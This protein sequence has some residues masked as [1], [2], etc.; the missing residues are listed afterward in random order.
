MKH[1]VVLFSFFFNCVAAIGQ[2]GTLTGTIVQ[3]DSN[4][5]LSGVS[6]YLDGV[7]LGTS[8][9]SHGRY[10]ITKIPVGEYTLVVS[11]IGYFT[12]RSQVHIG[13]D[14]VVNANFTMIE[15]ISTLAE[16]TIMTGGSSG[17][18]D[19]PGSVH[20]I[21]P[22]EIQRFNYTDI[23][24]ILRA[25]PGVN[26]QEEDGFGLRPNIGL[27]GTGVERS[28]KITVMEDGILMA[29]APYAA[30]AAYYFP[31]IGR[32]QA[33]EILKGSSQIKYG[34]Y[35]TG[36]AINLI[37]TH[38]PHE[39]GGRVSLTGGSYG[40]R[41]VH[42]FVGNSH[43]NIG[44]VAET[45][46]F[47]SNG[48]KEL[49]NGGE[50]GFDK[51]DYLIKFRVH[52]NPDARLYQ[53]L[54]FKAGHA[55]ET[56]DETYLGLTQADFDIT[57][58]RRY[59][60]SQKD[61]M[62]TEHT[63]LSLTHVIHIPGLFDI[64]TT[65]YKSEFS[66]NWYKLDKVRNRLGNN[67]GISALLD[68]PLDY[69][70]AYA[71]L[72]GQTST[73]ANALEVKANNRMYDAKGIQTNVRLDFAT[74]KMSHD[75]EVGIRYHEDQVD[76]FQ[77]TDYYAMDNGVMEQTSSGLPGTE[78]NTIESAKALASHVQYKLRYDNWTLIP[79]LRYEHITMAAQDFGKSD[80]DRTGSQLTER[81]NTVDV[82]IPGVGIDYEFNPHIS[83]FAGVHRGF[84]PPGSHDETVPEKS[85][86]YELG[87]RYT[88][89]GLSGQIVG[90]FNDYSNLLGSDLAASGGGGTGELFNGGDVE[91]KGVEFQM[92][93]DILTSNPK[94]LSLP[95][96]V[97]YTYT[98][99]IFLNDFDSDF[100]GWG[101]V[102][103]NDELPYLAHH[104]LAVI[105]GLDAHLFNVNVSGRYLAE[106]RTTP[107]QGE[108][109]ENQ[110][111]DAYLVFDASVNYK[112]HEH[113][114]LFASVTN[115]TD[116]VYVV[117]RR[118][119]GLRPG[120]PRAFVVGVKAEF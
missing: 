42:A 20:Y 16:V 84:A 39:F 62:K 61:V 69:D 85:I 9:N 15:T 34:P 32:M 56:S 44:Y 14:E 64:T 75:L 48:F 59:A 46:Q 4:T 29:P 115:L 83:A 67:I 38:I 108:I 70:D 12:L 103:A 96:S 47:G 100:E 116:Q 51:K 88:K 99:A 93:Y 40:G 11:N 6:V 92:A 114:A 1:I 37:S 58:Y 36:G 54:T 71:I 7:N 31:T 72:T 57:P 66:R 82:I 76:R 49:D 89:H 23:N 90:F 55:T 102:S 80:P 24:R 106:M 111:T 41:N 78:S 35:T 81:S 8:T 119:A 53:S 98:D 60:A 3:I 22:K 110:K 52:T 95:L 117:A 21:S 43:K 109:L 28:S 68:N 45:F 26:V 50:T 87:V 104:Q 19:V 86:N 113:I 18:K 74:G 105:L 17:I 107:G 2:F 73:N 5:T 10:T 97:V 65:A 27:R 25:I 94:G 63:Q 120:M 118:P 13:A 112:L 33:V 91:A 101:T 79:G 30:P 77:W